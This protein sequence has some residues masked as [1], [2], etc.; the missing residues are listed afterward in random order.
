MSKQATKSVGVELV[1]SKYKIN[2]KSQVTQPHPNDLN[3][4]L[5]DGS[6]SVA[7][8]TVNE[9]YL[10]RYFPEVDFYN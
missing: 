2:N 6:S 4:S 5:Q 10:L 3:L 9:R 8:T 7:G 1:F